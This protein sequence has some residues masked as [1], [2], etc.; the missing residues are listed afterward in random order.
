MQQEVRQRMRNGFG[1]RWRMAL[2]CIIFI[3]TY[4]A[5]LL[6]GR[7]EARGAEVRYGYVK[8]DTSLNVRIVPGTVYERVRDQDGLEIYLLNG[9][10][11]TI[12]GEA[13]AADGALWYQVEFT[14]KNNPYTGYCHS[15]YIVIVEGEDVDFEKKLEENGFP[16]SYKVLLRELHKKYPAWEF[17]GFHTNLNWDY[18]IENETKIGD[19]LIPKDSIYMDGKMHPCL[20]SWKSLQYGAFNWMKNDWVILSPTYWVQASEEIV[21]YF[22]DPRNFLTEDHIFQFEL[23]TFAESCHTEAGVELILKGTFMSNAVLDETSGL[24]YAQAF[25]QVGKELNVSPYHLA[26]R[27]KQEKGTGERQPDGSYIS[28]DPLISGTYPGYEGYYNYFNIEATGGNTYDQIV[29]NGLKEAKREGWDSRYKAL[30]GGSQKIAQRYI[31]RNQNT[32]YLQKFDVDDSDG[33]L[34]WRQ[35]MQNLLASHN[36]GFSTKRA[37]ADMGAMQNAFQFRI[38][39]YEDMPESCPMPAVDGNPNYKL[40]SLSVDG[41]ELSPV[42]DL[43]TDIYN[44]TV[45]FESETVNVL[46]EAIASDTAQ[47]TGTGTHHLEVGSNLILITV[48]AENGT[49]KVYTLSV[50]RRDYNSNYLTSL[51][52]EGY[53]LD[54]VFDMYH[55]E[56]RIEVP[57]GTDSVQI[58]ATP[59]IEGSVITGT[60]VHALSV[61]EN[62]IEIVVTA[63]N[64][65]TKTYRITAVRAERTDNTLKSLT[66][67][68]YDLT[69]AFSSSQYTYSLVVPYTVQTITLAAEAAAADSTVTGIGAKSLQ[70]G[71]NQFEITVTAADG[72]SKTYTVSVERMENQENF[73]SSLIIEGQALH[74]DFSPNQAD[75]SLTVPYSIKSVKVLAEALLPE[76]AVTGTGTHALQVG[77]N[78]IQVAVQSAGGE[79]KVYTITVTRNQSINYYLSS[80]TVSGYSLS[81]AFEQEHYAYTLTVP[82]TVDSVTVHAVPSADGIPVTGTGTTNLTVGKN[83]I[84]VSVANEDGTARN[85][86]ITVTRRPAM[87]FNTGS[88]QVRDGQINGFTIGMHFNDA[89]KNMTAIN[90][91]V[92][93]LDKNGK[94]KSG[95]L[96]TGDRIVVYDDEGKQQ[97]AYTVVIYGD[98]NGDGL[99]DLFD[100][101]YLK[102][103][104]WGGIKLSGIYAEAGNIYADS[105]GIDLFDLASFKHYLWWDIS[106]AQTR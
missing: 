87:Q 83:T 47:V 29:V 3:F 50:Y 105:A 23:L 94:V 37:Y 8:V 81:P 52:V 30:Y 20:S 103:E 86:V 67:D 25:M 93:Q 42:F 95:V 27:V 89:V 26:S 63:E 62:I 99:V 33:D 31:A 13:P 18:V 46:A 4:A 69:P 106:F 53:A 75:Y 44:I 80:L 6:P 66:A 79:T 43:D 78:Q 64:G 40:Q 38:P 36:E 58:A 98:V 34:F 61:G 97:Y 84:T 65:M 24:T 68:G 11:V 85:Y 19:N 1:R 48:T 90:C 59:F 39:I 35:Y 2:L 15:D 96:C 41:F 5:G 91:T 88:Y 9:Q 7:R 32:I 71:K 10:N 104:V 72:A 60:G 77:E 16:E 21:E 56:Y 82:N 73:L 92:K 54:P 70:V 74:P 76:A 14:Y 28:K 45:P 17:I 102:Q 22:M 12:L 57:Y 49:S 55:Y 101:A 51:T 100:Y